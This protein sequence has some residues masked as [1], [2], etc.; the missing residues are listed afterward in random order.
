MTWHAAEAL[1]ASKSEM[2]DLD[3][4]FRRRWRTENLQEASPIL[5]VMLAL[6][7]MRQEETDTGHYRNLEI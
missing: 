3:S 2:V 7:L 6:W 5:G 1:S 4:L